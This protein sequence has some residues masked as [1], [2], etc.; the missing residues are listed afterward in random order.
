MQEITIQQFKMIAFMKLYSINRKPQ[1]SRVNRLPSVTE[2]RMF[3]DES[4]IF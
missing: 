1:M 2:A 3:H 4:R